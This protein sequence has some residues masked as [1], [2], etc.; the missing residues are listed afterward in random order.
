MTTFEYVFFILLCFRYIFATG[1]DN[2]KEA[3]KA[4]PFCSAM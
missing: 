4:I 3:L 1:Q 2:I